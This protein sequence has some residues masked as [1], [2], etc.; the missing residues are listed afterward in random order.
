MGRIYG[1]GGI[2][3]YLQLNDNS[4]LGVEEQAL[5]NYFGDG[6]YTTFYKKH[7]IQNK[8]KIT[9]EDFIIGDIPVMFAA[10][11]QLGIEYKYSDYPESLQKYL[12]RKVW[13]S[14]MREVRQRLFDGLDGEVE[15]GLGW[16][17]KP[18]GKLKRFT[19]FVCETIDDLQYCNGAGDNIEIWCSEPV[20][21]LTEYRCPVINGKVRGMFKVPYTCHDTDV[22]PDENV[23]QEMADDFVNSPRGYCLDVGVLSTGET[24]L[25]EVNDGFSVG[26]YGMSDDLYSEL[27]ITRWNELKNE[28][29]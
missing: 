5:A 7:I 24:A 13:S 26:K 9:K 3:N 8:I 14:T 19:G 21:W 25:I 27:L 1:L 15:L 29:R 2:M 23:V 22:L 4:K 18:K 28:A 12:H 10:M 20:I 11:R 16:F 6:N 17:I